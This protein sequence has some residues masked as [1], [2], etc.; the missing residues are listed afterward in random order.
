MLSDQRMRTLL[1]A[2]DFGG[3]FRG[4]GW[5]NPPEDLKAETDDAD[6]RAVADKRGVTVWEVRSRSLNLPSRGQQHKIVRK[7][8]RFSRDQ[9]MVFASSGEQLWLWPEQ[10]PSG[11]G[12]RLVDHSYS[13]GRGNDA[14]LQ[15]LRD[16]SFSLAEEKS[17][18]AT[19]VLS[20]V[21]RSFNVDKVT[22]A[23]FKEFKKHHDAFVQAISGISGSEDRRWYASV[24]MNRL[25]FIYFIQ[26][27]GFM[28]GDTHYLC[29]RLSM[30]R[31]HLGADQFFGFF[32][33]F[34]MPLF[35]EGLG[36]SADHRA[37]R[38]PN[39]AEIV[40]D[41]P[42]IDGGI[43]EQHELEQEF[44]IQVP[45]DAFEELFD[46]FDQWRWHLDERSSGDP[47]EINPDILGYIFEQ[48][49]N[50]KQQ[51]AYYTKPDVTGYMATNTVIPAV[52]DRLVEAGLEDPCLLL[53]NSDDD[54]LHDCLGY[55][56]KQELPDDTPPS[57]TPDDSLD[58]ALP[59]ER[60]CEVIHRRAR[61]RKLKDLMDSGGVSDINE[62][63][64]QNLD[65]PALMADY[66]SMLRSAEECEKAFK[67]LRSLTVCD[68]TVGSGAFLLAALDVLEPMYTAVF[69]RADEIA[70]GGGGSA[71]GPGS[72]GRH[73]PT[74]A[75]DTGCL[76]RSA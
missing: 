72:C 37:Y 10:R 7:A 5:D 20:R 6:L 51:G 67:V 56:I 60:W 35:H 22:K 13:R 4:L 34:L 76:E 66:F 17:L 31:K 52:V 75:R 14:L 18:S 38:D 11:V 3:L 69:D 24:L 43:F 19:T 29:K 61:Y 50:K 48:Y 44:D 47:K 23:F 33:E 53:P 57:E 73:V 58:I 74:T 70:R 8:K 15:R 27:K 2:D 71:P 39:V 65:L 40:G 55:E 62:A 42:Y 63:V 49:V 30:V 9:L 26:R 16:A 21:R 32:S 45:D 41:I 25:M 36:K 54:Y 1:D 12:Y 28:A 68:P 46:F 59:G 64:T